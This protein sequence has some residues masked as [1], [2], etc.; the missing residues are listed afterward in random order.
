MVLTKNLLVNHGLTNGAEGIVTGIMYKRNQYV[1]NQLPEVILFRFKNRMDP[2]WQDNLIERN[3]IQKDH[4]LDLENVVPI[5]C[6][7]ISDSESLGSVNVP[8]KLAFAKCKV[9]Y[10]LFK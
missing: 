4:M 6:D 10:A 7:K 2:K 3:F 5:P 8:I 1:A 9:T